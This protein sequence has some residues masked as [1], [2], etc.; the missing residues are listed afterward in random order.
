MTKDNYVRG[1][2]QSITKRTRDV[3]KIAREMEL[4]F[5][6]RFARLHE[7]L[8]KMETY[9]ETVT[10]EYEHLRERELLAHEKTVA[11]LRAEIA[12]LQ[13]GKAV[14]IQENP[15]LAKAA[16]IAIFDSILFAIENWSTDGDTAPDFSLASQAVLFPLVYDKVMSGD[17]DYHIK[18]VPLSAIEVVKRGREYVRYLRTTYDAA[19]T[20][21]AVWSR[22]IGMISEW[23]RNDALPLLYGARD[24]AWDKD[25]SLSLE[26]IIV[27]R[28]QPASRALQ[29]PQ[30]FDAMDL[31]D[32]FNDSIRA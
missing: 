12:K 13:T 1:Q 8:V 30:V 3:A 22:N 6:E 23:W 10:R 26:D 7:H 18:R 19:L 4:K 15:H 17:T 14:E 29:F 32:R 20:D 25:S 5:A 31:M 16:T 24:D 2:M 9:A 27:W 21:P 11:T 28:D